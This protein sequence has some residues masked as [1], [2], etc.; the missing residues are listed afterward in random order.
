MSH[1]AV[2]PLDLP[3]PRVV[4]STDVVIYDGHCKFCRKQV[5]RLKFFD[6]GGRLSF[7]SLHDPWVS[8]TYPDLSHERLMEELVVVDQAG[9]RRGGA[10]AFRYLTRRLPTLWWLAPVMHIPL[11]LPVWSWCYRFI[12]RQRYRWGRLDQDC[13]GGTCHIHFR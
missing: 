5:E 10:A 12:A 8:E 4:P 7:V 6:R 11:S 9:V 1:A 2:A 3:D 13:D